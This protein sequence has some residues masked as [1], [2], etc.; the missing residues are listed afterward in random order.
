MGEKI[1]S[2]ASLFVE[3]AT[4]LSFIRLIYHRIRTI[5]YPLAFSL[6]LISVLPIATQLRLLQLALALSHHSPSPALLLC[7]PRSLSRLASATRVSK[8]TRC[9]ALLSSQLC[10]KNILKIQVRW[11]N[12]CIFKK[13]KMRVSL[14][15]W[16]T[17]EMGF[18]SAAQEMSVLCH[19]L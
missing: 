8:I 10:E 3:M 4:F 9:C 7:I 11:T 13:Q 19:E 2:S 12:S 5:C 14:V 6:F 17:F 1:E 15:S 16:N 18:I